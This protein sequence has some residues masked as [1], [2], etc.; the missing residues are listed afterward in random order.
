[1]LAV[2]ISTKSA[3]GKIMKDEYK[4]WLV[5]QKYQANTISAQLHRVGRVEEYYGNL[6][7]HFDKDQLTE[8]VSML[9]YSK[10]DERNNLPNPSK[11]PFNGNPYTNLA[12]YRDSVSRYRKYRLDNSIIIEDNDS[13]QNETID[14]L[15]VSKQSISLER[16]MQAALRVSIEQLELGLKV[17]DDGAER[18]VDSGFIDITAEDNDGITVVIE[19]KTGVAGQRAIAQILS[20]MGD[21]VLEQEGAKVRGILVAERFDSKAKAAARIIPDLDL[22]EYSV[23]FEFADGNK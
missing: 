4:S 13:K 21:I 14:G 6:D 15:N 8:V 16:D 17:T 18:S 5:Q 2:Q 20:Y 12:S 11:I 23:Q 3:L 7:E 19:L 10:N 1:M 22:R 9:V